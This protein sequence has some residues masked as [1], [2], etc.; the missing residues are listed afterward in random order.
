MARST[1]TNTQHR[2]ADGYTESPI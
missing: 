2:P 1:N